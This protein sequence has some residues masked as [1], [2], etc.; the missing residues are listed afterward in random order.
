MGICYETMS[1]LQKK[2]L[3]CEQLLFDLPPVHLPL[4]YDRRC[5]FADN[6]SFRRSVAD[7]RTLNFY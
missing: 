5:L 3:L 4:L 7:N 2:A 1:R 6:N